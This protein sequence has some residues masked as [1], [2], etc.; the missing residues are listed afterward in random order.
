MGGF[1]PATLA[2]TLW[3]KLY[4]PAKAAAALF[5]IPIRWTDIVTTDESETN[6]IP[7]GYYVIAKKK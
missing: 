4:L 1:F 6:R 7:A 3:S 5:L 2:A